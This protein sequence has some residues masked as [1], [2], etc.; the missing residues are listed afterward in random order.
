MRL[1]R[2]P[3]LAREG[4]GSRPKRKQVVGPVGVVAPIAHRR[5]AHDW[6]KTNDRLRDMGDVT[7]LVDWRLLGQM[8]EPSRGR[9][10]HRSVIEASVTVQALFNLPLRQCEGVPLR[11]V[12][13]GGR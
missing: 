7:V 5:P 9:A 8:R 12:H 3:G 11:P 6:S 13:L 4:Q 2:R 1:H 10:Y